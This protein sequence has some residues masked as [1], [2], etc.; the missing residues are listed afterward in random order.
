V[1]LGQ[2]L[3][4]RQRLGRTMAGQRAVQLAAA[5]AEARL[6]LRQGRLLVALRLA[7]GVQVVAP[8]DALRR[9]TALL[10]S[11]LPSALLPVPLLL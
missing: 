11:V 10:L 4:R 7:L 8:V 1:G 2:R 9:A 6:A 5:M 3:G